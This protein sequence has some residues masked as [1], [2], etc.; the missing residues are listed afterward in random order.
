MGENSFDDLLLAVQSALVAAQDALKTRQDEMLGWKHEVDDNSAS[1]SPVFTFA[2]PLTGS[3]KVEYE[4]IRLPASSFRMYNQPRISMLSLEFECELKEKKISGS[5]RA[6]TLVIKAGKRGWLRRKKR[7]RMRMVFDAT[8]RSSGEVR[9][10]GEL[11]M[12]IPRYAGA[13]VRRSMSATKRSIF[14]TLVNLLRN[15]WRSQKFCIT[16]DQA[17]RAR[18]ILE[19]AD[20]EAQAAGKA[21]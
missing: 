2:V 18:D 20:S 8:D 14:Q 11:L 5:T 16:G 4:M 9:L 6:Y 19:Q 7:R 17:K 21:E 12:E 15:L 1:R 10:D 3:D 13:G